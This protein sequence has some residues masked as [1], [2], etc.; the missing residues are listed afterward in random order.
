MILKYIHCTTIWAYFVRRH[1]TYRKRRGISSWY[2]SH[3]M[4]YELLLLLYGFCLLT[5][6]V[7]TVS[8][9]ARSDEGAS[10][11]A[12]DGDG[13]AGGSRKID[14]LIDAQPRTNSDSKNDSRTFGGIAPMPLTVVQALLKTDIAV[15]TPATG[16]GADAD[17]E[18]YDDDD[19]DEPLV[20]GA[21]GMFV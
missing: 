19:E 11:A 7:L 2:S 10:G 9:A 17:D 21:A 3:G 13:I 5:S 12:D 15:K 8:A 18:F 1:L 16:N 6:D 20:V 14:A 4:S